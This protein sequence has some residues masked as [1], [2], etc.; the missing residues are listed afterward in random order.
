MRTWPKITSETSSDE[1][2]A[3]FKAF[4]ITID[5]SLWAGTEDRAPLKAPE[6][7]DQKT[8]QNLSTTRLT[9]V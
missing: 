6:I 4:S 9:F 8:I 7:N 3:L 5:P 2:E 1:M